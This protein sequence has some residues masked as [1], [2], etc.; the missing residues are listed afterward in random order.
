MQGHMSRTQHFLQAWDRA[1]TT[2]AHMLAGL[3]PEK[4]HQGQSS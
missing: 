4:G 3:R 1:Q 2:A